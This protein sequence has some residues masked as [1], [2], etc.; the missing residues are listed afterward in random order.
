MLTDGEVSNTDEVIALVG[1]HAGRARVFTF[2]VGAGASQHLVKGIARAGEGEAEFIAPGERIEAKVMRQF[3]RAL[4]SA[5]SN[6]RVDWNGLDVEQAPHLPPPVFDRGRVLV[7]GKLANVDA[8]AKAGAPVSADK[9]ARVDTPATVVLKASGPAGDLHFELPVSPGQASPGQLVATLWARRRIRDLEEGVSELHAP[10]GSRQ[11]RGKSADDRVRAEVIRLGKQYGLVS[12]D[13]SY[14]A[15]EQREDGAHGEIL[16]RKVPSALARGWHDAP[17][18]ACASASMAYSAPRPSSVRQLDEL[19]ALQFADGTWMIDGP[20]AKVVGVPLDHLKKAL[21]AI[22][23]RYAAAAGTPQLPAPGT[24]AR[25]AVERVVA[26]A[27]ALR[28]LER[29]CFDTRDE[30]RFAADKSHA[31]LAQNEGPET[32]WLHA[33]LDELGV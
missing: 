29:H 14:V 18:M 30:W 27:L 2:G 25:V 17:A 3:G 33:L 5:L 28:W 22:A 24:R 16:L 9:S 11:G 12:R 4:S 26:T 6:V 32:S 10:R 15:V 8:A 1:E 7:Y 13:T 20:L 21:E 19:M 23:S 31:W